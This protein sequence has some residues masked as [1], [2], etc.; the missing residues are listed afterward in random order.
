MTSYN[1]TRDE[2]RSA[3][4]EFANLK[5]E[6]SGGAMVPAA[7]GAQQTNLVFGAQAVAVHRDEASILQKV[8]V[9]ATAAGT[10]WYYRFPVKDK[11]KTSWI[12][13]P[14]I[15]LANDIA[16][17]YGNCEVDCRAQDLGSAVM[18]HARF[19]DLETGYALTRP[20]QQRKGASKLGGSDEGRR[21]D[22]TFQIG[23]S[24][25]IRNVVVNALQTFADFAF[26]EAKQALVEKIG[27]DIEKWRRNVSERIGA[28]VDLKRV[29]AVIGRT[30]DKW[31]APDIAR[32]VAMGKAVEDGMSTWDETFPPLGVAA[33]DQGEKI[34]TAA[35]DQFATDEQ[36]MVNQAGAAGPSASGPETA[37]DD[38]TT[39]VAVERLDIVNR[40][41][42]IATDDKPLDEKLERLDHDMRD[43]VDEQPAHEAFIKEAAQMAAKV[44]RKDVTLAVARDWLKGAK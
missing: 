21:E 22:I 39:S 36:A 35:L 29:E 38:R 11:G 33:S 26:E 14:S 20:F 18:F 3:L 27:K 2:R 13:G 17:L 40:L 41:L 42:G 5:T 37:A 19:V 25:A 23:A 43:L 34:N 4:D 10:D 7:I 28:R 44:A 24:K 32:V 8:K 12:E 15:K 16:R 31:L 9:L 1:E 30:A 6:G